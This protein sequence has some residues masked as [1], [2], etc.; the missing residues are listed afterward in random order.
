M[1]N[2]I[3]NWSDVKDS[4]EDRMNYHKVNFDVCLE[5]VESLTRELRTRTV[6][7]VYEID[8]LRMA[9]DSMVKC[10]NQMHYDV[11]HDDRFWIPKTGA[12]ISLS[13]AELTMIIEAIDYANVQIHDSH[14]PV[15]G[16]MN[17]SSCES[18]TNEE[19]NT[20]LDI[21][22]D[23]KRKLASVVAVDGGTI[24]VDA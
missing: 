14:I 3:P 1:S 18:Y 6:H 15:Y 12:S 16:G 24:V 11:M 10:F 19:V 23:I 13:V 5:G 22:N 4:G 2:V 8:I 17:G 9:L 7:K 21:T 20:A